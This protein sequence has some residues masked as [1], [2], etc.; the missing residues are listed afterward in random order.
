MSQKLPVNDFK[1]VKKGELSNFNEDFIKKYDENGNVGYF[2]GVDFDYLKELF[3][4]HKDLPFL[5]ESK[6]VNKVEKLICNIENK[7]GYVI[8]I[9]ALKHASN[10][11]LVGKKVHRVI[12]FNQKYWLKPFI[13][14]NTELR[15][16]AKNKFEKY[17]FN[18]MNNSVF[19][20]TMENV[21][22]HRDIKLVT[23]AKRRE[24]LVFRTKLSFM[25]NIFRPFNGNRN[26]NDKSKNE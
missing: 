18:L 20:K 11:G 25:Q 1:W 8:H 3:N 22:N 19:A 9:R 24:R 13:D 10:H 23:L 7:E 26:E 6:K 12:Q 5:P 15:K 4:L 21:R 16:N 14:V 17:F 2:F